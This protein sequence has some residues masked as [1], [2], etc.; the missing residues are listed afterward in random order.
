[1]SYWPLIGIALVV[2]GFVLRLNPLL[3]VAASAIV[4]GCLGGLD[5]VEVIAALGKA[6]NDNRYISVTWIVLPVIGLLERYGLQQRARALI[7][8]VR[9]ATMGRL[10]VLYLGLRQLTA[11]L[12]MKDIGGHPQA[13]RPLVAPMA[14]AAA[15][16]RHGKLSPNERDRVRAM[17][18]A[19]DNVG[20]FFGEDIFFAIASILLIQGVFEAQGYPLA[21]LQLSVWAIPSA[22]C[23]F[24]IHGGRLLAFDRSLARRRARLPESHA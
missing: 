22:I 15:E 18:A 12:G 9:G 17:A 19:T 8:S 14:E 21:P 20:L 16:R 24:L 13:V 5:L 23:A 11:A 7:A 4:T 2:L 10:L 3:V 6:F 1:M